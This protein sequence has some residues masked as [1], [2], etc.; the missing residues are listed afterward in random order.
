V[1]M[2]DLTKGLLSTS[3]GCPAGYSSRP[4]PSIPENGLGAPA[5]A[6]PTQEGV[7]MLADA[8]GIGYGEYLQVPS[9]QLGED[10]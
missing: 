1:R 2:A 5:T 8:G 7:N 9:N 4:G 6:D 3:T 10:I